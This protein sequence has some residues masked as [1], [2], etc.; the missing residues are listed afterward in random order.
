MSSSSDN[1]DVSGVC[2]SA[3]HL[4]PIHGDVS[5]LNCSG[6]VYW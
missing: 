5:L 4:Q 3:P 6:C 2:E 1:V